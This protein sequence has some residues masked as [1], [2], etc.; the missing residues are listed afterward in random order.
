[1]EADDAAD[2]TAQPAGAEEAAGAQAAAPAGRARRRGVL[3]LAALLLV[4]AGIGTYVVLGSGDGEPAGKEAGP[5]AS[6]TYEVT[7]TGVA[8]LSYRG[9]ADKAVVVRDVDLPWRKTV[10]V[11]LGEKPVVQVTLGEQGGD[12]HC[13]L[14]VR[15]RQVQSATASGAFG[16]G[17]C[18]GELP[19]APDDADAGQ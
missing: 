8:S 1:M 7:G 19:A 9:A 10:D 15:G 3:V 11:P 12:A 2:G 4:G 17:T 18:S 16:R 6:V 5:T 14:A 13:T